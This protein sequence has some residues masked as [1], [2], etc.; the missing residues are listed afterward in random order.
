MESSCRP[1]DPELLAIL[2]E[3]N[4]RGKTAA[5]EDGPEVLAARHLFCLNYDQMWL[6]LE[7]K[8]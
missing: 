3:S 5:G 1:F 7:N 2:I 8:C 6:E 4:V